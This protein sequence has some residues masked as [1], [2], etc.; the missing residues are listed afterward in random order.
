MSRVEE[1][2]ERIKAL[3]PEELRELNTWLSRYDAEMW[4]RQFETDALTGKL[5]ALAERALRDFSEQRT[6]DL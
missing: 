6:T 5:D 4:D 1:V 3:S 2:E